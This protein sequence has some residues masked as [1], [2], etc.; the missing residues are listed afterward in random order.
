MAKAMG[1]SLMNEYG[2]D[3]AAYGLHQQLKSEFLQKD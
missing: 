3:E 2:E 1:K